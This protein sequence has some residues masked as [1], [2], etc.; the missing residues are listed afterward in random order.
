MRRSN[1][2]GFGSA[3]PRLRVSIA[4]RLLADLALVMPG[5]NE[6]GVEQGPSVDKEARAL[7]ARRL[8]GP[9]SDRRAHALK[10][11]PP[12][13]SHA[14]TTLPFR[15]PAV[16][17]P[18]GLFAVASDLLAQA[19]VAHPGHT[20]LKER[21]KAVCSERGGNTLGRRRKGDTSRPSLGRSPGSKVLLIHEKVK[22]RHHQWFCGRRGRLR[23]HSRDVNCTRFGLP[24]LSHCAMRARRSV[25]APVRRC[26]G[27]RQ[28]VSP[29]AG[30]FESRMRLFASSGNTL[31]RQDRFRTASS[32]ASAA[33]RVARYSYGMSFS[34]TGSH[35][36]ANQRRRRCQYRAVVGC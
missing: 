35:P 2:R 7:W 19:E 17:R 16:H 1:H 15:N 10:W 6:C 4:A 32:R 9:A 26:R 12:H 13:R 36:P 20:S 5:S 3:T 22:A 30:L 28:H 11:L 8:N 27:S 29:L 33:P 23:H 34:M 24:P 18:F 31:E 25:A 21:A 14:T